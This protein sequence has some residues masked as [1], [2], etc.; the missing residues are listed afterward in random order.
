MLCVPKNADGT[1][2]PTP[3]L[4]PWVRLRATHYVQDGLSPLA[5]AGV[6]VAAAGIAAGTGYYSGA[7]RSNAMKTRNC[8]RDRDSKGSGSKGKK[9]SLRN[10][11]GSMG[12]R[13]SQRHVE[14]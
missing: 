11:K 1:G 4:E 12:S 14:V 8:N 9:G 6:G 7:K 5:A 2:C 3:G 10:S 13:L